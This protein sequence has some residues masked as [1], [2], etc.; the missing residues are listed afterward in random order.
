MDRALT[1]GVGAGGSLALVLRLLD[2]IGPSSV[3]PLPEP[4]RCLDPGT[5]DWH[6]PSLIL[7]LILGLCLGPLLEAIVTFRIWLYHF[8]LKRLNWPAGTSV[9]KSSYRLC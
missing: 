6:I 9:G 5:F 2:S 8:A 4:L 7:G 3:C 1:G